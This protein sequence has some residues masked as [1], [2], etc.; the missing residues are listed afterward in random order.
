MVAP[1]YNQLKKWKQEAHPGLLRKKR[2]GGR[3]GEGEEERRDRE[4]E[5]LPPELESA[6]TVSGERLGS[7]ILDLIPPALSSNLRASHAPSPHP[8]PPVCPPSH[9]QGLE[10]ARMILNGTVAPGAWTGRGLRPV[11]GHG[12]GVC[13]RLFTVVSQRRGLWTEGSRDI[14]E[15]FHVQTDISFVSF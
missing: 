8:P 14:P 4:K 12:C 15:I 13:T 7:N 2:R 10:R 11:Q 3:K 1:A 5:S 9:P 6:G